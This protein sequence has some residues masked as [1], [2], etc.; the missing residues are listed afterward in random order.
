MATD[1]DMQ[2]DL[3]RF[4]D[5]DNSNVPLEGISMQAFFVIEAY[6]AYVN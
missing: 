1:M 5:Y 4:Y 3:R 2:K 6:F